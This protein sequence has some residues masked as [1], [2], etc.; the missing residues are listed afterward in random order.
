[1]PNAYAGPNAA[2]SAPDRRTEILRMAQQLM[3][4]GFVATILLSL[5]IF[6]G[7][8][9][10]AYAVY[11]ASV[12][13]EETQ[14]DSRI[15]FEPDS[16]NIFDL[17]GNNLAVLNQGTYKLYTPAGEE[18]FA[19]QYISA[20][21]AL[22]ISDTYACL[23]S[24]DSTT[25]TV[26][27]RTAQVGRITVSGGILDVA[28]NSSGMIVVVHND[29]RYRS[30]VSVF[31]RSLD[32]CYEWKTSEYYVQTAALSPDGRTLAAVALTQDDAVFIT[33]VITFRLSEDNYNSFCD[34]P[35]TIITDLHFLGNG[36]LCAVGDTRACILNLDGSIRYEYDYGGNRMRT[37]DCDG[38]ACV[39]SVV[40]RTSGLA[41]YL[42]SLTA[43]ADPM[44]GA[45]DE[46]RW[47]DINNGYVALLYTD[48]VEVRDVSLRTLSQPV[49]VYNVRRVYMTA[50]GKAL[51][52]YTS[53]AGIVD[54][55]TPFLNRS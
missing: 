44:V 28:Q 47:I 23:Y 12:Q 11:R 13:L 26:T 25:V 49:T 10:N 50:A 32:L 9:L 45:T 29:D 21:P 3:L 15:N 20:N 40:D 16:S 42:V 5:Y 48:S 19:M 39:L 51:L 36:A 33:R 34:L 35:E 2:R 52:I 53:E 24:R 17:Y 6:R 31:N 4:F 18:Q 14:A 30:V 46:I 8:I 22:C 43:T 38:N 27:E 54:L 37:C 1:M 55:V 7:D 41:S